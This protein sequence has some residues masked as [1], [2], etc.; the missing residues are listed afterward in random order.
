MFEILLIAVILLI[1][2][3]IL[4]VFTKTKNLL[5]PLIFLSLVYFIFFVVRPF[6][7][8]Y[9][10][11]TF[12]PYLNQ[13][14]PI[15]DTYIKAI[16]FG[17]LFGY[18]PSVFGFLLTNSFAGRIG[19]KSNVIEKTSSAKEIPF[20]KFAVILSLLLASSYFS[21]QRLFMIVYNGVKAIHFANVASYGGGIVPII[22]EIPPLIFIYLFY[23]LRIRYFKGNTLYYFLFILSGGISILSIL[24]AGGRSSALYLGGS[25]VMIYY[26]RNEHSEEAKSNR[27]RAI[28]ILIFVGFISLSILNSWRHTGSFKNF[29]FF[30]DLIDY[31]IPFDS[32][33]YLIGLKEKVLLWW[34]PILSFVFILIPRQIFPNKPILSS[35]YEFTR[36]FVWDP[37][38]NPWIVTPSLWGDLYMQMGVVG[39]I[40]GCFFIGLML[41]I[42]YRW[43]LKS[44]VFW[45]V[46]LGSLGIFMLTVGSFSA[47]SDTMMALLIYMILLNFLSIVFKFN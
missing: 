24:V 11:A 30:Y 31:A 28:L 19:N 10:F 39:V 35:S 18:I 43:L 46:A 34:K 9:G 6:A 4:Y 32:F 26:F 25:M 3:N 1:F 8:M 42:F 44:K 23:K 41:N 13:D 45:K 12:F 47:F 22:N 36:L 17:I 33:V 16:L 40:I 21:M 7:L 38:N 14:F 15:P 2:G 5:H 37:R 29:H 27:K 20:S